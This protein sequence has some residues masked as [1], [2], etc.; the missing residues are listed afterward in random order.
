MTDL[1]KLTDMLLRA[2]DK[3]LILMANNNAAEFKRLK[4]LKAEL[5]KI[6]K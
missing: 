1:L 6:A 5:K 4:T 3:D 2:N